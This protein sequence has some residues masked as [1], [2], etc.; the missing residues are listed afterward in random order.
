MKPFDSEQ[1]SLRCTVLVETAVPERL[2]LDE[3]LGR[4][5]G[6]VPSKKAAYKAAKR[7]DIRV[8]GA[9]VDPHKFV[10]PG[11]RIDIFDPAGIPLAAAAFTPKVLYCDPWLAIVDKPPGVPVM[12]LFEPSIEQACAADLPVSDAARPL[13]RAKPVHRLD[14]PTGGLVLIARTESVLRELSRQFRDREVRKTYRAIV[15]GQMDGGAIDTPLDGK[16]CRTEYTCDAP[17]RS[18]ATDWVTPV[19]L[20]PKTGRTH[21]LRRHLAAAGHPIVGDRE[22]AGDRR[23]LRGKGLFLAATG[24]ALHHPAQPV[25]IGLHIPQPQKFNAYLQREARRFREFQEN[26]QD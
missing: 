4:E 18:L 11:D 1:R 5:A 7:G 2:R 8:N 6:V 12:G 14:V 15:S 9:P 26:D 24:L 25:H 16:P 22:H 19:T 20:H 21:Q 17:V 10:Q 3:Y 13:P 23:V